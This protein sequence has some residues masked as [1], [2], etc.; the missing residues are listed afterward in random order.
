MKN[1]LTAL[2]F[3]CV[4]LISGAGTGDKH[5]NSQHSTAKTGS[6]TGNLHFTSIGPT[7][8][9]G[10]VADL[11]VDPANPNHF[12][13]AYASGGLWET[14]NNGTTFTPVFDDQPTLTIGAI[15]VS[16]NPGP[17]IWAGTGESNSSRSSYAGNGLYKSKDGGKTWEHLGLEETHHIG[18][19]VI[20]PQNPDVVWV[21]AIG[22]LYTNNPER[23]VYK[24]TDG[25]KT[26][27]KTLFVNDSTGAIDLA[28]DPLNPDILYA[29]MW[30]RTRK[31]WNFK[32]SGPGSAIYKSTN[33][34]KTWTK[35][36]TGYN[37]FPA[38][39]G[40]GRI[41][42]A[43]SYKTPGL[44]YAIL[45]NQDHR[46]KE[47]EEEKHAVTKD[48]L[49]S[50]SVKDF[51]EL[52]NEDIN[53]YLD[54]N[55]FPDKY[56]AANIKEQVRSGKL[57]PKA[58]VDYLEDANRDLFDTPVIAAEVYRSTDG[59]KTWKKTHENFIDGFYNSY[60]YYFGNIRVA[61]HDD[62][63]LYILG[64][65]ILRSDD[66][67]AT[68]KEINGDNVHA[69]HHAL[70][71]NPNL[72]G[73]LI[74]GNDGGVNI[75]YDD[76][77]SWI[78]CNNLP[79]GQFYSV[80]VDKE[81]NYHVYGGLQDNGVW[82]GPHNYKQSL[83]WQNSGKYPFQSLLGGDGMQVEIDTRDNNTIYAGF[84]FGY[85]YRI[86][87][88][89]GETK[90]IK[91][92]HELGER[93][94]RFN[95]QSP[96]HLSRHNQDVLYM[97][98]QKFHRSLDQGK[99]W[100]LQSEDLTFGGREGN[101]PYGTLTTIDESPLMFGLIYVGADDGRVHVSKDGGNTFEE[102]I[103][104]LEPNRWVSRVTASAHEKSRV[105]VA[106]NG[107]RNDDFRAL[108]YVSED[109]GKHWQRIGTDL[110]DEPVNVIMEDPKNENL[111]YAGTDQGIYV[112]LDRGRHF[113][114]LDEK[115]PAVAVHDLVVQKDAHDLLIGTHGRSLYRLNVK[116][117]Q[118]L[119]D[120]IRAKPLY[121]FDLKD[122]TFSKRW[123]DYKS[124]AVWYGYFEPK[125]SI[126]LYIPSAGSVSLEIQTKDGL[127][128][129]EK[130]YDLSAGLQNVSYDLT[131]R[132]ESEKRYRKALEKKGAEK[133]EIKKAK[134]GETYL[135][136]GSYKAIVK[137]NGQTVVREFK[138]KEAKKNSKRRAG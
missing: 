60:G 5:N 55:G 39:S 53:D 84:Q 108:V 19:I 17:V 101:V 31:A 43:V 95:W 28:I 15:A 51:L 63:K 42:I 40:T 27:K 138:V 50:I 49:R 45:D 118:Q 1:L 57:Q 103:K 71:V 133:A 85:Y 74:N 22:H 111:L 62:Q 97:G 98:S 130:A 11:A 2:L 113:M 13:A 52:K 115:L 10:R 112:S 137:A 128:L 124:W 47:E 59:G 81:K 104:G 72:P 12:F 68:W 32:G 36:T 86:D 73:H 8:M 89:N 129:W 54:N 3:L 87:K 75:S 26:W 126:P 92:Q 67:G 6:L 117:L 91:P 34:G 70:W 41:G 20:H 93:P 35:I 116:H 33:G 99:N 132:M 100:D 24:T 78:K 65:P 131:V 66:G 96:I 23:G 125:L 105:Y 136:P 48:L 4:P 107:Y 64:V 127:S 82:Y 109:Y 88:N 9:S 21:A 76:G 80:N 83:R 94:L 120:T 134:N 61:P 16:W 90:M 110:P 58:L 14:N 77:E 119:T 37:G 121:V 79:V 69:D 46:K 30:E 122:K 18:R 29:A 106:L 102:I 56:S 123:G 44:V 7:L 38:T 114:V 135:Q 25:G